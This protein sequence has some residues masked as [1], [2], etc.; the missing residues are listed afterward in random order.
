M[1]EQ[2]KNKLK[3]ECK[4][5]LSKFK[6][7]TIQ[8]FKDLCKKKT[9]KKQ[10]ANSL[11][12]ARLLTPFITIILSTIA[13]ITNVL[14]LFTAAGIITILGGCTD[15]FDGM[16]ARKTNST[17]EYGK[18]LDQITDKVFAILLGIDLAIINP[19]FIIPILGESLIAAINL[20]YKLNHKDLAHKSTLIGRIKEFPLFLSLGLGYFCPVNSIC[21]NTV[22]LLLPLTLALQ[23]ATAVSYVIKNEKEIKNKKISNN[24]NN[25]KLEENLDTA[26]KNTSKN[27]K[28][29]SKTSK[30]I[31]QYKELKKLLEETKVEEKEINKTYQKIK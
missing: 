27:E 26:E 22:K 23:S 11:S 19:L 10:I 20:K 28:E 6:V 4:S 18:L 17:S 15:F 8:M 24:S 14:P 2:N 5:Y 21:L 30:R 13:L 25:I 31:E 12:F 1:D 29:K 3:N 16:V 9:R 7:G